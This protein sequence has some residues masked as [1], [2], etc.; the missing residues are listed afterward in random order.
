MWV[1]YRD[2]AGKYRVQG[3]SP[4]GGSQ[5]A[6]PPGPKTILALLEASISFLLGM[7]LGIFL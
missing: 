1:G 6:K 7:F 4:G 5:G 3:Q 2:I